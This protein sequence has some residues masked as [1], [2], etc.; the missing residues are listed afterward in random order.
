MAVP[1]PAQAT[2]AA[3]V[4]FSYCYYCHYDYNTIDTIHTI[5]T[6]IFNYYYFLHNYYY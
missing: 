5:D 2:Q 6:I 3:A 1:M 4:L